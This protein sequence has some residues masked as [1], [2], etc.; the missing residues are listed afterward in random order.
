M[1]GSSWIHRLALIGG[2]VTAV[3]CGVGAAAMAGDEYVAWKRQP[4]TTSDDTA[5]AVATDA[6][7]NVY[8]TGST[9][10]SLGAANQGS[11]DAWV[12]KYDAVGHLL[13][14]RQLGTP[15][16]DYAIG[17][18]TDAAGHVF[19]TGYTGGSLA[20]AN[21]GLADPWVAKYDADG[22]LLWTQQLGSTEND[23]ATEAATD[24]DGNVYLTGWTYG[25]LDGP[26]V[27]GLY[28]TDAWMAKYDASGQLIWIRQLGTKSYDEASGVAADAA[29]NVYLTGWTQGSLGGPKH[30]GGGTDT[31]LAK[32][33]ANGD[34]IWIQQFGTERRDE[35][36]GIATDAAG[37][38]YLAGD[39]GAALGSDYYGRRDPW[40]AKFD[41]NGQRIWIQ[42]FGGISYEQATGVAADADGNVYLSGYTDGSLGGANRGGNDAWVAKFD[43]DGHRLWTRQPGTAETDTA[44]D[45]ATDAAGNA[46]LTGSTRGSLGGANKGGSDAW[47][48]KFS[49]RAGSD[50]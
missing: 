44:T 43:T 13:W 14:K 5:Y 31:W 17:M 50:N 21:Q 49:E 7:G 37:N 11:G 30:S 9:N 2:V 45:V 25:S 6:A 23:I 4:G 18:A 16:H 26:K 46:Y 24:T 39:T 35:A 29:G 3:C 34:L 33:N 10:G 42:Q 47:V 1:Q 36:R 28:D 20:A 8:L 22:Q 15:S 41:A 32:Y 40:V 19:L 12:A 48:M 27:G 38:V